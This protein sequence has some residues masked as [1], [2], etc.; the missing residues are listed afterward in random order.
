VWHCWTIAVIDARSG[1]FPAARWL[2]LLMNR[3]DRASRKKPRKIRRDQLS[4]MTKAIN[5]RRAQPMTR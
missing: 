4:T 5:G 1:V 2:N 3:V